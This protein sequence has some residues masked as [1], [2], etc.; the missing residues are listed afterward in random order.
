MRDLFEIKQSDVCFYENNLRHFL[1]DKMIDIH[2]HIWLDEFRDASGSEIIRSAKWHSMVARDNSIEDLL[3]TYRLMFPD[4]RITP[5]VFGYPENDINLELNN[6][7]VKQCADKYRV[8]SLM[9]AYPQWSGRE[10]EEKIIAGEFL[11]IKVYLNYAPAYI[12]QDEIRVFD[13]LPH[14]QMEVVNS[15]GMIVMLHIPR[16]KRIK[17]PVNLAQIIEITK[18]Y[19][20][21]KLIIAHVGR[22]YCNEDLGD[23]FEVLS[24]TGAE[25][26]YFDFSANTNQYIFEQTIKTFGTERILFGSDLPILRMR[27]HRICEGGKYINLVPKGMYG[28]VSGDSHMREVEGREADNLTF[29]MYEELNAFKRAAQAMRLTTKEIEDVFYNNA[30]KLINNCNKNICL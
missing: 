9:L 6:S 12:P 26:L 18:R 5:M 1:P 27:S 10:M 29:F 22:A 20:K 19:P 17:D 8:P 4:K 14:H 7:Y 15:C 13:F 2:T 3:Q 11:G 28:D 16:S 30:A 23:A 24:G 21:I 25:N